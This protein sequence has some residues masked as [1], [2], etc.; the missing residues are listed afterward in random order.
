MDFYDMI[1]MK[2][3]GSNIAHCTV[4]H[5][6]SPDSRYFLTATLAPRMNV[7]NGFRIFKYNGKGPILS[8]SLEQ[9]YDVVWQNSLKD[10]YPNRYIIQEFR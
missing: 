2:K 4:Q 10:V 8:H 7:D 5:S 9:A 3:I 6:W 1:R